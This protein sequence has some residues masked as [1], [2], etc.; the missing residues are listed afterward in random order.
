MMAGPCAWLSPAGLVL[1]LLRRL[2]MEN[3]QLEAALEWR[4]RELI[5]WLIFG[6][7][8][9]PSGSDSKESACGNAGDGCLIPRW[10]RYPVR[11]NGNPL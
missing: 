3:A 2:E 7:L 10:E 5:F 1:Q 8:P 4:R 6:I 11:G 9:Y